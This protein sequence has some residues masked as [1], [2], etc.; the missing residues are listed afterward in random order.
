MKLTQNEIKIL[1]W[2][3]NRYLRAHKPDHP[4][5]L[6]HYNRFYKI[7]KLEEIRKKLEEQRGRNGI[8]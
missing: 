8:D 2:H 7:D 5:D 1:E 4:R 3:L 6:E